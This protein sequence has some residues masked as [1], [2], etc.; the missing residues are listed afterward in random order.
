VG[1]QASLTSGHQPCVDAV[2][3]PSL[4]PPPLSQTKPR[5]P[6]THSSK[7]TY[8]VMVI[9]A[10]V[11]LK[12]AKV[13]AKETGSSMMAVV[14]HIKANYTVPEASV[15]EGCTA[16]LK[17]MVAAGALTK[18]KALFKL[19]AKAEAAG[20]GT[21]EDTEAEEVEVQLD[22]LGRPPRLPTRRSERTPV[23]SAY[24]LGQ[25]NAGNGDEV[26][27]LTSIGPRDVIL[28]TVLWELRVI[29]RRWVEG[30]N[31]VET[32]TGKLGPTPATVS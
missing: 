8:D 30:A 14:K 29:K 12:D 11:A 31:G 32:D 18:D 10:L 24:A 17:Q 20:R 4:S 3:P 16:A 7:P 15:S 28:G 27:G 19:T 5:A 6:S 21:E 1:A 25:A 22:H 9:A 2:H 13:Y 23:P 26:R